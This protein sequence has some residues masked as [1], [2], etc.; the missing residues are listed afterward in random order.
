[1]IES[2]T[3]AVGAFR[4]IVTVDAHTFHSDVSVATGGAA[5]AP[6]PHDYFDSALAACKALTLCSYAKM[7][8]M[9]LDRVIVRVERDASNERQGTYV[10]NVELDFEGQLSDDER[11][12]LR[13]IS[14]RCPIHKLMTTATIEINTRA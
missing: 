1:M 5:S 7:K 3:E 10:M 2:K 12:R 8:G 6:D 9:K 11:K 13:E 4:Q 14:E